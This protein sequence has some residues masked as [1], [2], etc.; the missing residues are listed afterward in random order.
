[1]KAYWGS[2]DIAPLIL[3]PR[4]KMEMSGQLHTLATLYPGKEPLVPIGYE[5]G[6][7][8]EPFW[9]RWW[10]EKFPAPNRNRTLEPDQFK[11]Q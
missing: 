11:L 7:A 9:M 4:H 1:M 2:G 6:W 5:A 8:P 10:R 3:W